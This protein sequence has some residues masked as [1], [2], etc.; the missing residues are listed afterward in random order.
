MKLL[1]VLVGSGQAGDPV[2]SRKE[3]D[4]RQRQTSSTDIRSERAPR[5]SS[6]V[7][8]VDREG[9]R[10]RLRT[11]SLGG[12]GTASV[13]L[14]HRQS[15]VG[16]RTEHRTATSG[17]GGGGGGGWDKCQSVNCLGQALP[18]GTHCLLHAD[19]QDRSSY[20][21]QVKGGRMVLQLNGVVVTDDLW[22]EVLTT[23]IRDTSGRVTAPI[24][25]MGS[26]FP[27]RLEARGLTFEHHISLNG[28]IL[29]GGL[30]VDS[31]TFE[32]GLHL[33]YVD[34]DDHPGVFRECTINRLSGS[35][36]HMDMDRQ[37]LAFVSCDM[38][39]DVRMPGFSGD[40][41]FDESN[42][43]GALDLSNGNLSHL[44]LKELHLTRQLDMRDM[45]VR[46]LRAT[47]AVFEA[48]TSIGPLVATTSDFSHASFGA[49]IQVSVKGQQANF[50]NT[51]WQ[52]GGRLEVQDAELDLGGVV[53]A[54]PVAVTGRGSASVVSISDADAGS[55][56]VSGVDMSRC[57]L[58]PAH[59]L[60]EMSLDST[61]TLPLAPKGFRTRRRCVA[62]EFAWRGRHTGRRRKV[63]VISGTALERSEHDSETVVLADVTAGEVAG[64]YRSLRRARES[65]GNE[66]GAADFYYGE[67]E[68]RRRDKSASWSER[69]IILMYW[70]LSGYGLRATRA[71][72]WLVFALASSSLLL[73]LF[74]FS[75]P[76]PSL[77]DAVLTAVEGAIPG[78]PTAAAL[79]SWGRVINLALTVAGPVLFGLAAL[80]LR[81][82]VKR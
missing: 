48:S 78:V 15:R 19:G 50:R 82:R 36:G 20:Y 35:F 21:A 72:G 2:S 30:Q 44:S 67:M 6:C 80:A 25:C 68:M 51:V 66:P 46:F 37:H 71:V 32:R 41:R 4:G 26:V 45:E 23:F 7:M 65:A 69:A 52:H 47:D 10:E 49:R 79:T 11:L 17:G 12:G 9:Q 76:E 59:R 54:S 58:G 55:L 27:F 60:Q 77:S 33:D 42:I 73:L 43:Q 56:S 18:S 1:R 38:R 63:W 13:W 24:S 8:G 5:I 22:R 14:E 31:C 53:L 81:N 3:V 57:V 61:V 39:G 29:E 64:V 34:F 28:A 62:D 40:L 16:L 75:D 74:G 70:L